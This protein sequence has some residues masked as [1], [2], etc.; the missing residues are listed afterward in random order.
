LGG[1]GGGRGAHLSQIEAQTRL[2]GKENEMKLRGRTMM[3]ANYG[4]L[5]LEKGIFKQYTCLQNS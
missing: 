5:N 3:M 2:N 4:A 1:G